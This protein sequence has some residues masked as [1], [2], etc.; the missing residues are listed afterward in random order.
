[1]LEPFLSQQ[2]CRTDVEVKSL[3]CQKIK[4]HLPVLPLDDD[5][6]KAT[7]DGKTDSVTVSTDVTMSAE[8]SEVGQTADNTDKKF[9]GYAVY[10]V[11]DFVWRY[12]I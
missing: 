4:L 11:Q 7:S 12:E 8:I 10:C 6:E 9:G 2:Y 3:E 1:M 5:S